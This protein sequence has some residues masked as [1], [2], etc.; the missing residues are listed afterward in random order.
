MNLAENNLS[1]L[2]ASKNGG[3]SL[4]FRDALDE[5]NINVE[6]ALVENSHQL[7]DHLL[8]R[9]SNL[10]HILFMENGLPLNGGLNCLK[11]IRNDNT[12]VDVAIALYSSCG[13]D[14]HVEEAMTN[15]ANIFITRPK[16]ILVMKHYLKQ[17]ITVFWQYHA[18]GLR[19]EYLLINVRA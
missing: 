10:P 17:I 8:K 9:P 15:G 4:V 18:L 6:L 2:L 14:K 7:M 5:L 12:L 13:Y 3:D 1:L 16:D 11:E 19:K